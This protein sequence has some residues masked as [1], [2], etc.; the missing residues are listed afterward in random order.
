MVKKLGRAEMEQ[1]V[2][3]ML[4]LEEQN[5][6]LAAEVDALKAQ[7]SRASVDNEMVAALVHE[8][9]ELRS[10]L[11]GN[12]PEFDDELQRLSELRSGERAASPEEVQRF[13]DEW[14]REEPMDIEQWHGI[15]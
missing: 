4:H 12:P 10:E 1:L 2:E 3:R 6:K 7:I 13:F 5:L 11:A 9:Q 14:D 8:V 15:L